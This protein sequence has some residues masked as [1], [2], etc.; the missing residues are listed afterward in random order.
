LGYD[1]Q[2]GPERARMWRAQQAVLDD[3]GVDVHLPD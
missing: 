3:L 1:D 2:T